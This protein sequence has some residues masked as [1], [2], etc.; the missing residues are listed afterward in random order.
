MAKEYLDEFVDKFK[1]CDSGCILVHGSKGIGKLYLTTKALEKLNL[2]YQILNIGDKNA[3]QILTSFLNVEQSLPERILQVSV[4]QK[5]ESLL[6]NN[7]YIFVFDS[8]D[9][10]ESDLLSIFF[11]LA[12]KVLREDILGK[13]I[14]IYNDDNLSTSFQG[15]VKILKEQ[16]AKE[17]V[18]KQLSKEEAYKFIKDMG[19]TIPQSIFE[20]I[21][22]LSNGDVGIINYYLNELERYNYVTENVFV[23][24]PTD[25]VKEEIKS[26]LTNSRFENTIIEGLNEIEKKIIIFIYL[27]KGKISVNDLLYLLNEKKENIENI[28]NNLVEKKILNKFEDKYYLFSYSIIELFDEKL[29]E[30]VAF[31]MATYLESSGKLLKAAEIYYVAKKY[32]KVNEFICK[33]QLIKKMK[34]IKY[35]E[36]CISI[37]LNEDLLD[38]LFNLYIEEEHYGK[39]YRIANQL[40]SL[41]PNELKYAI[42]LAEASIYTNRL[43]EAERIL[44]EISK[45]E[46]SEFYPRILY[47]LSELYYKKEKYNISL[48]YA[49]SGLKYSIL[50]NN[51]YYEALIYK[52]IGNIYYYNYNDE[53]SI[54]Y[55]KRALNIFQNLGFEKEVA[56]IY[57][58]LGNIYMEKD[59]EK[60]LDY[61]NLALEIVERNWWISLLTT[62]DTNIGI[63]DFIRGDLKSSLLTLKK[64]M[65]LALSKGDY[66][67][68][69]F[70]IL[71]LFDIYLINAKYDE[72]E[73]IINFGFNLSHDLKEEITDVIFMAN[74][75][76]IDAINGKEVEMRQ[77]DILKESNIP[78][79]QNLGKHLKAMIEYYS[80]RIKN[81]LEEWKYFWETGKEKIKL[82]SVTDYVSYLE[83]LTYYSFFNNEENVKEI[84][85]NIERIRNI[86]NINNLRLVELRLDLLDLE[87]NFLKSN[88][89]RFMQIIKEIEEMDAKF[90]SIKHMIIFG[91]YMAKY[92]NDVKILKMGL[93]NIDK[94]GKPGIKAIFKQSYE[95]FLNLSNE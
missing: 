72:A 73:E 66:D 95:Y 62:L 82:L 31:E 7:N 47:D 28:L 22:S 8:I 23:K 68:A 77:L 78:V 1:K 79:E 40:K 19:Y 49:I 56:T 4:I 54:N 85:N 61:Y 9:K 93:D 81:Y 60:G 92:G 25:E 63:L 91:L 83:D 37:E 88:A 39:A 80:G 75:S 2:N 43:D 76:I 32:D 55:Y 10:A 3:L 84:V 45:N 38:Y 18:L 52:I 35:C 11:S 21:Y 36:M 15:L 5:L 64:S 16:G 51:Q 30:S 50:K 29:I 57:N 13:V 53:S 20:I 14:G 34:S 86:P 46:D 87:L 65:G 24:S 69:K 70:I 74:K 48:D 33:T 71:Y 26:L 89:N 59:L 12:I 17:I 27:L 67:L 94:L 44:L 90:I 41:K 6:K 58:N 42:Y